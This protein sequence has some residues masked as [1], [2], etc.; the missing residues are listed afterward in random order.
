MRLSHSSIVSGSRKEHSN[1]RLDLQ[2]ERV[3]FTA[4]LHLIRGFATAG[5]GASTLGLCQ[6]VEI[7]SPRYL[8]RGWAVL[9]VEVLTAKDF[10]SLDNILKVA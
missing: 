10:A 4:S 9:E 5:L 3:L 1:W 2:C 7:C 8:A 6:K